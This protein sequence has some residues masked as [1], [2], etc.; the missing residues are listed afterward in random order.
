MESMEDGNADTTQLQAG[1]IIYSAEG[2][3]VCVVWVT[4][5]LVAAA[6]SFKRGLPHENRGDVVDALSHGHEKSPPLGSGSARSESHLGSSRV[7]TRQ[8]QQSLS[9]VQASHTFEPRCNRCDPA[10]RGIAPAQPQVWPQ[11]HVGRHGC[12]RH[13]PIT[14]FC[15]GSEVRRGRDD[16]RRRAVITAVRRCDQDVYRRYRG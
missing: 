14:D 2:H 10:N 16:M 7:S 8:P 5:E 1:L 13:R 11:A 12:A 3:G 6:A 9:R 15:A 4:K